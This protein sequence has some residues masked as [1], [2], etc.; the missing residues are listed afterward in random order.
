[1]KLKRVRTNLEADGRSLQKLIDGICKQYEAGGVARIK[2]VDPPVRIMGGGRK[3]VHLENPFV[4]F[5]GTWRARGGRTICLEAKETREPQL[6]L[7]SDGGLTERQYKALKHWR[8][9]GAAVGVLWGYHDELRFVPF[10]AIQAQ[11]DSGIKH[12]KWGNATP[13]RR[14]PGFIIWDFLATLAEYYPLS[15]VLNQH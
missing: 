4:D 6:K 10:E 13:V 14:G 5:I 15:G 3:I 11:L 9:F 7:V 1:M 2:K 12:L 8:Q